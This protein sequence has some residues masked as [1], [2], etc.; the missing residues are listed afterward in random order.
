[1][2]D[3][4]KTSKHRV[5]GPS[6]YAETWEEERLEAQHGEPILV[7]IGHPQ[8]RKLGQRYRIPFGESLEIG[9]S[10]ECTISF[11]D[12][13]S[14]SRVHSRMGFDARGVWVQDQ[15]STNGTL[16]N[17]CLISER[18]YLESG[19]RIEMG[20]ILLKFLR[21]RDIEAAYFDTLHQLALQDGLTEIANKR[22]FD[23]ELEREFCRAR[24]HD[25]Q[26]S[27]ILFDIDTLKPIN[28]RYGHL[29]GDLV[30]QTIARLVA[31][32]MRR[33]EVVAR[34]GGD[35]FGII[36]AEVGADGA[37]ILAERLRIAIQ[38]ALAEPE[39]AEGKLLVTCS[40]GVAEL[41]PGMANKRDLV[42]AADRALR[43]SKEDGRN[44]VTVAAP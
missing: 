13:L 30:L 40:F 2:K 34:I 19:D 43:M 33:E 22:R 8:T 14:V 39:F 12:A 16:I 29:C 32:Q 7:L 44:R 1:M 21:E 6:E 17:Q 20:A 10:N 41:T 31:L 4:E 38:G 37:E 23:D 5:V 18:T 9:R 3:D 11:P 35:E 24:R 28:D 27:L 42:E 36:T 15:G 26:L 25:R